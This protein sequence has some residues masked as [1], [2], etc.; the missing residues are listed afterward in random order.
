MIFLTM[1]MLYLSEVPFPDTTPR[2][3]LSPVYRVWRYPNAYEGKFH[4]QSDCYQPQRDG[5]F[6]P[7]RAVGESDD[8]GECIKQV[9]EASKKLCPRGK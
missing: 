9:I 8:P 6:F 3:G 4:C 2:A 1:L 7:A 5:G